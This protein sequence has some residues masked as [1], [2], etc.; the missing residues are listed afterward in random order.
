MLSK[1]FETV[2]SASSKLR[3]A[4]NVSEQQS[5]NATTA[6]DN[7]DDIYVSPTL[8]QHQQAINKKKLSYNIGDG[9]LRL[10]PIESDLF[11]KPAWLTHALVEELYDDVQQHAKMLP[12]FRQE[13]QQQHPGKHLPDYQKFELSGWKIAHTEVGYVSE[14]LH[15]IFQK[16][17]E[18]KSIEIND[19]RFVD[20]ELAILLRKLPSSAPSLEE[21]IIKDKSLGLRTLRTLISFHKT[22]KFKKLSFDHL[23]FSNKGEVS[24][25]LFKEILLLI[26][27][28]PSLT[29]LEFKNIPFKK[30]HIQKLAEK[31]NPDLNPSSV[32][33]PHPSL[34]WIEVQ[35]TPEN[36]KAV[37]VLH[38]VCAA[39]PRGIHHLY[40]AIKQ[41]DQSKLNL[42]LSFPAEDVLLKKATLHD[43]NVSM[44][45]KYEA[46]LLR[47][48]ALETRKDALLAENSFS[49]RRGIP[50]LGSTILLQD[51]IAL[52]KSLIL[53]IKASFAEYNLA[54]STVHE[55]NTTN[56]EKELWYTKQALNL[57]SEYLNAYNKSKYFSIE[58]LQAK[59]SNY[60]KKANQF[61]KICR[62][63]CQYNQT[64]Q[65]DFNKIEKEYKELS[66]KEWWKKLK[67][68]LIKLQ[69][70][71]NRRYEG[72][73]LLWYA[74]Q[75]G[76]VEATHLLLLKGA[77]IFE[78]DTNGNSLLRVAFELPDTNPAR[79]E[80]FRYLEQPLEV[81]WPNLQQLSQTKVFFKLRAIKE[82]LT[83]LQSNTLYLKSSSGLW[84]L[85]SGLEKQFIQ[86]EEGIKY[87]QK[88]N[89]NFEDI[90]GL[91]TEWKKQN[92]GAPIQ[93]LTTETLHYLTKNRSYYRKI[94]E[95]KEK[96][97]NV[98]SAA[99]QSAT[100]SPIK[101]AETIH[102]TDIPETKE[103]INVTSPAQQDATK[104]PTKPAET[105]HKTD[106]PD[107]SEHHNVPPAKANTD[108]RDHTLMDTIVEKMN[109][110]EEKAI[111]REREIQA[112]LRANYQHSQ[113]QMQTLIQLL[114]DQNQNKSADSNRADHFNLATQAQNGFPASTTSARLE[115]V[116]ADL[117]Y[118]N[119]QNTINSLGSAST[120]NIMNN[121][122]LAESFVIVK[123]PI[124]SLATTE[125][126]EEPQNLQTNNNEANIQEQKTGISMSNTSINHPIFPPTLSQIPP[127][128][129]KAML[130]G[131]Q[132]I[133]IEHHI[134]PLST[135]V[136]SEKTSELPLSLPGR[137]NS[138]AFYP[139][140]WAQ[141]VST[142][143]RL[144]QDNNDI[145]S[146]NEIVLNQS[147]LNSLQE[148]LT[149]SF[150]LTIARSEGSS[151]IKN[152]M[153]R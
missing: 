55:P 85:F 25:E 45:L 130:E 84:K 129:R 148:P 141:R 34:V 135:E 30:G 110:F 80:L 40:Q 115:E 6:T 89:K 122:D 26:D 104:S 151:A 35:V 140:Q 150:S 66:S 62:D 109:E 112:E 14:A 59:I 117:Q 125:Q 97:K 98:S 149:S 43:H 39:E 68:A 83:Q 32:S 81:L 107:N 20:K 133:A 53:R 116:R 101:P 15:N 41:K 78:K 49:A 103:K 47:K 11:P 120:N 94:Q 127:R 132:V 87:L 50:N 92:P 144:R 139:K 76:N 24:D 7:Q 147:T 38:S 100:E 8:S 136:L 56:E 60:E 90:C 3:T 118:N 126:I 69:L 146:Q 12:I 75:Q 16:L 1:N 113:S 99:Q 18:L 102:K 4:E 79:N 46:L 61:Q 17:P 67:P 42:L 2:N 123:E 128:E 142:L 9:V 152:T 57:I 71:P 54:P 121:R 91:F 138:A 134:P 64:Y 33:D 93:K 73:P 70:D 72:N 96:I 28:F 111:K 52:E 58:Q 63:L 145:N 137:D 23:T 119:T 48:K 22:L 105:I 36:Q 77:D 131:E 88:S 13:M 143:S 29:M 51:N 106:I 37:K 114:I 95:T 21:L 5:K 44:A 86:F 153:N 10:T 108:A 27:H 82:S 19:H 74:L 65:K 124:C 31:I